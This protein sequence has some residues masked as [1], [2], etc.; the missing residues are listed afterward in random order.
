MSGEDPDRAGTPF[1]YA[2]FLVLAVVIVLAV[3]TEGLPTGLLPEMSTSLGVSRPDVGMLVT[4]YALTVA[5]ASIPLIRLTRLWPR[6]L[7]LTAATVELGASV[8]LSAVAPSYG[9][10]VATRVLGGLGHAVF[11]ATIGAYSGHALRPEHIA[12]GVAITLGGATVGFVLGLPLTTAIGQAIGWRPTFAVVGVLLLL[13]GGLV[14]RFLP[15]VAGSSATP[16]GSSRDRSVV[17][18][19]IVCLLALVAM[20]GHYAF[21]T[22]IAA[23][24]RD[25]LTVP[26]ATVA[27]LLLMNGVAGA[28]G[29]VCA[30]TFLAARPHTGI[31]LGLLVSVAAIG[32]L[33]SAPRAPWIALPAMF[34]WSMAFGVL[35]TLMQTLLLRES[36]SAFRDTGNSIYTAT[37]NI[38]IGGGALVGALLYSAVGLGSLPWVDVAVLVLSAVLLVAA[39]SR[40]P[41]TRSVTAR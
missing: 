29:L 4:V 36:S 13:G 5:A 18:V 31:V 16:Q 12:R 20:T 37:F 17:P 3:T 27:A 2:G 30:G 9:G 11:W 21:Y 41:T 14:R 25:V 40:L 38:G 33:A 8:V 34:L 10:L 22:Y 26:P 28:I 32:L 15:R 39:G 35:P 24:A 23:Y 1:P 7:L 6:H 19:L